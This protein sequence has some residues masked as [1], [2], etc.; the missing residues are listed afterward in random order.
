MENTEI[1]A[2]AFSK[3]QY[4]LE[5]TT[6]C[7]A[8]GNFSKGITHF[9]A[10]ITYL[11]EGTDSKI[12]DLAYSHFHTLLD[13]IQSFSD[14]ECSL[15]KLLQITGDPCFAEKQQR[16]AFKIAQLHYKVG[17][18]EKKNPLPSYTLALQFIGKAVCFSVVSS[19]IHNLA[20]RIFRRAS[21]ELSTFKDRLCVAA[22]KRE[23]QE[24]VRLKENLEARFQHLPCESE[25]QAYIHLFHRQILELILNFNNMGP[26][27]QEVVSQLKALHNPIKHRLSRK[28]NASEGADDSDRFMTA[29]YKKK[30][31]EFRQYFRERFLEYKES[32]LDMRTLQKEVSE[33][34]VAYV[35]FLLKDAFAILGDPPCEYD[36]R[37]MGSLG[38]EEI[39]P[40][41]DIE[42]FILIDQLEKAPYFISLARILELQIKALG[43]EA[44]IN[45]PIFTCLGKFH[46]SGLHVDSE[47]PVNTPEQLSKQQAGEDGYHP[48]SLPNTLRKSCSL[49]QSTPLLF[50]EYQAKMHG[51]YLDPALLKKNATQLLSNR[52]SQYEEK[53]TNPFQPIVN[54]KVHYSELLHHLLN[55]FSLYF[56]IDEANTLDV[57][58]ELVNKSVFS[59]Q[60]GKLL[61]ESV[62]AVYSA[63]VALHLKEE[64]QTEEFSMQLENPTQQALEK[65]YWIV[66]RPI[67]RA[68]K[69]CFQEESFN[70][71][72]RFRKFS[73]NQARFF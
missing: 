59:Q 58:E 16:L 73:F 67:Y 65:V 26:D 21:V 15:H 64:E 19:E 24:T 40:Y 44:P 68:L 42:W 22:G 1:N 43:E 57:I 50:E 71:E 29:R 61:K 9:N 34:F 72:S 2:L 28:A 18:K 10:C 54:L 17:K 51:M 52:L 31:K 41:S 35:G 69:E 36:L 62:C 60:S 3:G 33:A 27:R 7:I 4:Y 53:W 45:L 8:K 63:R 66:L 39:C 48:S 70:L 32:R 46:L 11:E 23:K 20:S 47:V 49:C 55:D 56:K 37:A 13:H 30:L 14:V 5:K 12:L 38:K 6:K 25:R